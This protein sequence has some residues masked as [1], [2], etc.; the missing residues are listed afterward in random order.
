M[1]TLFHKFSFL[2]V[3]FALLFSALPL[4][5]AFAAAQAEP[6]APGLDPAKAAQRLEKAFARQ[7]KAVARLGKSDELIGRIE[8]LIERASQNGKDVSAIL[9]ALENLKTALKA[10]QPN[11]DKADQILQ[12]HSGFDASGKVTDVDAARETVRGAGEALH[13]YRSEVKDEFQALREAIQ[14][15]REANPRPTA[16]PQG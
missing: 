5:P 11:L 4:T 10:A 8:T 15:F 7:Q 16:S 13:A 6:P 2:A 1:K 14:A 12:A 9:A 3:V